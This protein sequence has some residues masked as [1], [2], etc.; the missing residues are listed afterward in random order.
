MLQWNEPAGREKALFSFFMRDALDPTRQGKLP[1]C[2]T[3]VD[4]HLS[5]CA[6]Q[7]A[8]WEAAREAH[9]SMSDELVRET[10]PG[11]FLRQARPHLTLWR[12]KQQEE[13]CELRDAY[14]AGALAGPE[15]R[16]GPHTFTLMYV[17]TLKL[18]APLNMLRAKGHYYKSRPGATIPTRKPRAHLRT[19]IA[20]GCPR[21]ALWSAAQICRIFTIESARSKSDAQARARAASNGGGRAWKGSCRAR[22]RLNPLLIPGVL[23]SAIT[24]CSYARYMGVC[25][26]CRCD[27]DGGSGITSTCIN[28]PSSSYSSEEEIPI[29]LFE[30]GDHDP[31]VEKWKMTGEGGVPYWGTGAERT[32]VCKCKLQNVAAWFR[33]AFAEDERAEMEFVIFLAELSRES[34]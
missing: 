20:S 12:S 26:N 16:L 21:S 23:M 3:D 6:T 14:F 18:L 17:S 11:T 27:G 24:A 25:P 2:L 31:V 19:W 22:L 10:D 33:E 9:S 8:L 32:T 1:Y 5:T 7:A 15:H 4:Y 29:N 13:D 28:T 30:T 34:Q